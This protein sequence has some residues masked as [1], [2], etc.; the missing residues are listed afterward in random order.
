MWSWHQLWRQI[1]FALLVSNCSNKCLIGDFNS[2]RRVSERKEISNGT[3]NNIDKG[4]MSL[5]ISV[6]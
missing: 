1:E 4:L 6:I 3:S 2:V 5:L